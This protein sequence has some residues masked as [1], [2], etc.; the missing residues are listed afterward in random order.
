M[1][2]LWVRVCR[3]ARSGPRDEGCLVDLR[4]AG[5]DTRTAKDEEGGQSWVGLDEVN[6]GGHGCFDSAAQRKRGIERTW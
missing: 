6:D 4:K 3:P 1:C 5:D 2:V